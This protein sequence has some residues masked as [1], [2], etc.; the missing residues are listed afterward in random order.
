[1]LLKLNSAFLFLVLSSSFAKLTM[2]EFL[3][4]KTDS[5]QFLIHI[6]NFIKSTGQVMRE[7]LWKDCLA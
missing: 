4:I 6:G 7:F 5:I 3:L 1:M 2:A